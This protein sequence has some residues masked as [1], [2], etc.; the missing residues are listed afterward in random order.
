MRNVWSFLILLLAP[1]VTVAFDHGHGAW[2]AL[3]QRH[4]MVVDGGHVSQLDYG[5]MLA[6]RAELRGYLDELSAVSAR[7]FE[8]WDRSQRLAFLINAYN[9]FTV[10]L[11]L[12]RYPDLDSIRD[13]GGL[14]RSPWKQRF[15]TLLGEERHLDEI[16][17]DMIRAPGVYDEPRIHAAV[18]CASIGCPM[19]PPRAFVA[20][21]LEA[22]LDE[23]MA[24]F[25]GHRPRNLF[26]ATDGVLNV[27][28]IFDWYGEDFARGHQGF[29]S[30]EATFA[31]Y[32]DYLADSPEE[33]RRIRAGDYRLRFLEYDWALNDVAGGSE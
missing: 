26:E 1:M 30:L 33:R 21:G 2:D 11:I 8:I 17:H 14:F 22:Q 24:R 25:L 10:E 20:E 23:A 15:F 31:R 19:L 29:D 32:A 3:L 5:A 7:E 18:V 6:E 16:E 28:R 12:T 27:S 4:V 9:A 13:L